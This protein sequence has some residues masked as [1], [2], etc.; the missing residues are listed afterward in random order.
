MLAERLA[1]QVLVFVFV[2][3]F[4]NRKRGEMGERGGVV[5]VSR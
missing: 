2:A 4:W 3:V 1:L 5:V